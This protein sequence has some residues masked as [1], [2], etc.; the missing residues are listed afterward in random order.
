MYEGTTVSTDP[1]PDRF[2]FLG[3]LSKY[4]SRSAHVHAVLVSPE[5]ADD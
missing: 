3:G 5:T 2:I 1:Q 4:N